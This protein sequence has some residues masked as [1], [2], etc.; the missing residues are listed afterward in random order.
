MIIEKVVIDINEKDEGI[1]QALKHAS[2][3]EEDDYDE[4]FNFLEELAQYSSNHPG[5]GGNSHDLRRWSMAQRKLYSFDRENDDD[6]DDDAHT[7]F[8]FRL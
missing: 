7:N 2:D 3:I 4:S 8:W 6:D 1:W 5:L